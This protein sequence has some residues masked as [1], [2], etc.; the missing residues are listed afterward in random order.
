MNNTLAEQKIK[1]LKAKVEALTTEL[2]DEIYGICE[3]LDYHNSSLFS[4]NIDRL[5]AFYEDLKDFEIKE[6]K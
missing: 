3:I 4:Y 5:N 1:D 2:N 6:L